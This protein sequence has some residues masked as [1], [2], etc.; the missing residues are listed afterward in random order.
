MRS[1][2]FS[3]AL[4]TG[5]FSGE[6]NDQLSARFPGVKISDIPPQA[7][8][9]LKFAGEAKESYLPE[10]MDR[11][12]ALYTLPER[13]FG[14]FNFR[15][16]DFR[17]SM[18]LRDYRKYALGVGVPLMVLFVLT[19]AYFVQDYSSK[20]GVRDKLQQEIGAVFAQTL[21]EVSRVVNPLQQLQVAVNEKKAI[22]RPSG[23][24]NQFNV[25]K[26]LTELSARIPA[27]YKVRFVRMVADV[28]T[29]RLR[30]VTMDFNTVD[31][32]QKLL[33]KSPMFESVSI[34]SANQSLQ[35]N[36]VRFELKLDLVE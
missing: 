17:K 3:V 13:K 1:P 35:D 5:K 15:K 34:S 12:I 22:Y 30:G 36:E 19:L 6:E 27:Q 18:S 24:Q 29:I 8:S 11:I 4:T 20:M 33:E 7:M 10:V 23:G 32:L 25:L 9:F 14:E 28:E 31:S 16:R 26:I 2:D 21:P